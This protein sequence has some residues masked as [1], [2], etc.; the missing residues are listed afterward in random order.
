MVN[1]WFCVANR[2]ERPDHDRGIASFL[3]TM[4][5]GG[6]TTKPKIKRKPAKDNPWYQ[7]LKTTLE[8]DKSHGKPRGWYWFGAFKVLSNVDLVLMQEKL[9]KEHP[10]KSKTFHR[11]S[12]VPELNDA[13]LLLKNALNII[14]DIEEI[15]FSNL[16][17]DDEP[18]NFSGLIFPIKVS[19]AKTKFSNHAGFGYAIFCKEADFIHAE[20]LE[21]ADF[22]NAIF[23]AALSHSSSEFSYAIFSDSAI[24]IETNFH[25]SATFKETIFS[26]HAVFNNAKFFFYTFFNNAKFFEFADFRDTTFSSLAGLSEAVFSDT[27]LFTNAKFIIGVDFNK[28]VFSASV[29]FINVKFNRTGDFINTTFSSFAQFNRATLESA[30]FSSAKFEKVVPHF[31]DTKIS[32]DII[33]ELNYDYWPPLENHTEEEVEKNYTQL[34]KQ[35]QN[36]YENLAYHMEGLDKYH[37]QHFFF[38][39]EMRCRRQFENFFIRFPYVAYDVLSDYGYSIGWAFSWWALHILLGT[40]FIWAVTKNALCAFPVSFANAHGFLPFHKGSLSGCYKL[41][42]G[43]DIFNIIWGVQTII[44]ILLLFM[45]LLTLRIRFRLK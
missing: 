22:H 35:N 31:Y 33:W 9:P 41:F 2:A 40:A 38:R 17:F 21:I 28:V 44:G 25:G 4:Y 11:S 37:D 27:V 6:M 18:S 12:L 19:F 43:N 8:I 42:V 26:N 14:G 3:Y 29:D 13:V 30:N 39:Q 5:R 7:F 32:A 20:F 45:L 15:N 16:S 36:A 34:V 24:F 1:K 10:L 23:S